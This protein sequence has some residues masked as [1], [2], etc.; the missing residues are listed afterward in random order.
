MKFN[1]LAILTFLLV[2]LLA[3]SAVSA[4]DDMASLT[5]NDESSDLID[6]SI[7]EDSSSDIESQIID[8]SNEIG[9]N[10]F[11]PILDENNQE[12]QDFEM[13]ITGIDE[14]VFYGRDVYYKASLPYPSDGKVAVIFNGEKIEETDDTYFIDGKIIP[15]NLIKLGTNTLQINFWGDS[16]YVDKNETISFE[17]VN[18]L[19]NIPKNVSSNQDFYDLLTIESKDEYGFMVL[20][21]DGEEMFTK[22]VEGKLSLILASILPPG[23]HECEVK[24]FGETVPEVNKKSMIE[25]NY[26]T[27]VYVE[28]GSSE[29]VFLLG[30]TVEIGFIHTLNATGNVTLKING[31]EYTKAMDPTSEYLPFFVS[32]LSLGENNFTFYYSGDIR[33]PAEV[34]NSDFPVKTKLGIIGPSPS[35]FNNTLNDIRLILPEDGTGNLIVK[36]DG[37]ESTIPIVEGK[38]IYE[39]P[40]SLLGV[41]LVEAFYQGNY[42][43]ISEYAKNLTFE[44]KITIPKT[45]T[46]GETS[47]ITIEFG[48]DFTGNISYDF[49]N[50]LYEKVY[51]ESQKV[52]QIPIKVDEL[53]DYRFTLFTFE[54]PDGTNFT[55]VQRYFMPE[56]LANEFLVQ[57]FIAKQGNIV[58]KLYK[59][60]NINMDLVF[61]RIDDNKIIYEFYDVPMINGILNFSLTDIGLGFYKVEITPSG[62]VV[63]GYVNFHTNF[64]VYGKDA[65][66]KISATINDNTKTLTISIDNDAEGAYLISVDGMKFYSSVKNK[67]IN[68]GN[69][70][71]GK[72]QILIRY[73]G[74]SY[75]DEFTKTLTVTYKHGTSLYAPK[76]KATYNSAKK[77]V[78]T[79]KSNGKVLANKKITVKVGTILKTLKTN[80]KGQISILVSKL[81]PK[82]YTATIK[83]AG[84]NS[85]NAASIKTK[86]IVVKATPKIVASKKT[87]NLYKKVKKVTAKLKNNKGKI[88][89]GKL[90]RLKINKKTYKAITNKKGVATFKVKI[91]KQGNFDGKVKFAGNKFYKP[92]TKKITVVVKKID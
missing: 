53:N 2:A 32:D 11:T 43:G 26:P 57:N 41:H 73:S 78:I 46:F 12:K 27:G 90:L 9:K 51:V 59:D 22:V 6:N 58:L 4:S 60:Y 45:L 77:L 25:I 47:N 56:L 30:D 80:A 89:K 55:T 84:D 61:K 67:N 75:F 1:S 52:V 66:P 5:I 79:L 74:D 34:R 13:N 42:Q 87:F 18:V 28:G 40:D 69:L 3:V 72:H 8:D 49:G 83:F 86:V 64:T 88:L 71:I 23:K 29:T 91:N 70:G 36:I 16:Q 54:F 39:F 44:P 35:Q 15:S 17:A 38:A 76:V 65:L 50:G 20:Y 62:Q 68:L 85:Y 63:N 81:V 92:L 31:H 37:V 7:S 33:L 24:Y 14:E 21:I 82:T 19:I 10:D 48:E